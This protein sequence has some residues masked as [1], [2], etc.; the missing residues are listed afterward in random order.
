M[1]LV[2]NNQSSCKVQ[3]QWNWSDSTSSGKWGNEFQ[4]YKLLRNYVP[5]GVSDTFDYG[6]KVIVTKNK[7][8]GSGKTL[9]LYIKSEEGKDMKL[10]GW[11]TPVTVS[12]VV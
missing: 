7:L 4:A 12:D 1:N 11:G 9:S 8:R 2:L 3:A 5:T 10:L 6:D